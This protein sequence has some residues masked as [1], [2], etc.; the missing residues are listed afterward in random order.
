MSR[1]QLARYHTFDIV[2]RYIRKFFDQKELNIITPLL[3]TLWPN[4]EWIIT[5]LALGGS[6][7]RN[8]DVLNLHI[9][10]HTLKYIY[11][12]MIKHVQTYKDCTQPNLLSF[13]IFAPITKNNTKA[14]Y[15]GLQKQPPLNCCQLWTVIVNHRSFMKSLT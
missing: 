13:R 10:I 1:L 6:I 12:R 8:C 5:C 3:Y 14:D 11:V 4:H 9:H 2:E 15:Y 7:E